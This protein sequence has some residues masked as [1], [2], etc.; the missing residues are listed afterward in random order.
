MIFDALI[1]TNHGIALEKITYCRLVAM[2]G[3]GNT[4]FYKMIRRRQVIYIGPH[5]PVADTGTIFFAFN[6]YGWLISPGF[7]RIFP[8]FEPVP[9]VRKCKIGK[10]FLAEYMVPAHHTS[11]VA[12][13]KARI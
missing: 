2:P 13:G 8:G 12:P 1:D 9:A 3:G 5:G 11:N 6:K 4:C 7:F 10:Y